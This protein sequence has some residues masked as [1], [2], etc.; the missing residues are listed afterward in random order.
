[1]LTTIL[2]CDV[3]NR[4]IVQAD[5]IA[6]DP[7]M[8]LLHANGDR[9]II[10]ADYRGQPVAQLLWKAYSK[11]TWLRFEKKLYHYAVMTLVD[12][13]AYRK[14]E[15]EIKRLFGI[16]QPGKPWGQEDEV[17]EARRMQA[18]LKLSALVHPEEYR[19]GVRH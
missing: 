2:R 9:H 3:P 17:T 6:V 8:V 4:V 15:E 14:Q 19:Q 11:L 13:V 5:T 12:T 7:D 16:V 1:M 10:R 18:L